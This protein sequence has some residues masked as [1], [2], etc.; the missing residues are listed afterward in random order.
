MTKP[1]L[2]S[3]Q[4]TARF[5]IAGPP[6]I[7]AASVGFPWAAFMRRARLCATLA[8]AAGW[9]LGCGA[10]TIGP[11]LVSPDGRAVGRDLPLV[12][13][14]RPLP[15]RDGGSV[16]GPD[17][18]PSGELCNQLDDDHDGEVDEH[19]PCDPAINAGQQDCYTGPVATRGQG[20]CRVGRQR[21]L[22]GQ[23]LPSWGLCNGEVT[24]QTEIAN[25][26]LDNDCDGEVD[27]DN[28][29]PPPTCGNGA[30]NYP[31]C[32]VNAGGQCLNGNVNPPACTTAPSCSNGA[33]NY[34]TCTVNA[35]GQCLNGNTNPPTCTTTP[36]CSNWATNYPTCTVN[37]AGQ[38]VNGNVNPPV[39]NA[40]PTCSNGATNY[41]TCTV[42][43]AGQCLNGNTNPPTCT[44][45]PTCSNWA[46]NYPTCTVNA[47][48][49]CVNGN[50]NPP[51][52]TTTPTCGNG[53]T[54]YPTCTVNAAGQCVNGNV[55]PPACTT[56][57]TC[58]NGA[59]NY[60]TCTVNAAG[61][62]VNGNVNPPTCT[63]APNRAP[64]QPVLNVP[65]S[66]EADT[67]FEVKFTAVDVDGDT[68]RYG[69]DATA[70]GTVDTWYPATGYVA[71]GSTE[72]RPWRLSAGTF[73]FQVLAQDSKGL[74]S[75]WTRRTITVTRRAC[76][77]LSP[78][79]LR[80]TTASQREARVLPGEDWAVWPGVADTSVFIHRGGRA[81]VPPTFPGVRVY[82]EGPA[83]EYEMASAPENL[84]LY[85][86][87]RCG[88]RTTVPFSSSGEIVTFLFADGSFSATIQQGTTLKWR[89]RLGAQGGI[90]M[91]FDI[92]EDNL[93]DVQASVKANL[94]YE[95][96]RGRF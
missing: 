92:P 40:T 11:G 52:C 89:L 9:V 44:T 20:I 75:A 66:V 21:C 86:T 79:Q 73:T 26:R 90:T 83:A 51:A 63:T 32:T 69:F 49:Q 12:P 85:F 64:N 57:P 10:E 41:P 29:P 1:G 16:L 37:A 76:P 80:E 50:V 58:G 96:S 36:T 38:C 59:T 61:Q 3:P 4:H 15:Q 13:D 53:A 93:S 33:T 35:A 24:P 77:E 5:R 22:A 19:C 70:D 81:Y 42:N 14:A 68:L 54:N 34:P 71:S 74:N 91:T 82:F 95:S 17:R 87:D 55:N 72:T 56:A 43:A 23:A 88:R 67:A 84:I 8:L 94:Y 60:P 39:C 18:G 47:A 45:T 25:D 2:V 27:E 46:T 65:S 30:T 48:G 7:D 6:W 62:C 28:T 31:T 78:A